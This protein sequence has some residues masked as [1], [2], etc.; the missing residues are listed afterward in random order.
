MSFS[1]NPQLKERLNAIGKSADDYLWVNERDYEIKGNRN[2]RHRKY[3]QLEFRSCHWDQSVIDNFTNWDDNA[4]F[5]EELSKN[6]YIEVVL[7]DAYFDEDNFE[8]PVGRFLTEKYYYSIDFLS[9]VDIDIFIKENELKLNRN[10]VSFNDGDKLS[11]YS[12][13]GDKIISRPMQTNSQNFSM[14]FNI[15]LDQEV[16]KYQLRVYSLADAIG[17]VGGAISFFM[18]IIAFIMVP[19]LQRI[20]M[21]SVLN[22]WYQVF[23]NPRDGEQDD[24][25][26]DPDNPKIQLPNLERSNSPSK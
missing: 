13:S 18:P 6:Y 19:I 24:R 20:Y 26:R 14:Y 9:R 22:R 25:M 2:S 3:V 10:L 21:M 11:F 17:Q 12:L 4:E 8:D 1:D 5:Y 16:Q 15:K 23:E 7:V